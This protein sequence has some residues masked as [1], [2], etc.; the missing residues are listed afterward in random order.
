MFGRPFASV[1]IATSRVIAVA[2]ICAEHGEVDQMVL[3]EPARPE[4]I[5]QH[6]AMADF[7]PLIEFDAMALAI[8]EADRLDVIET[9]QREGEAGGRNPA[10]RKKAP[11]PWSSQY[12]V[13]DIR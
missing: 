11:A 10:R 2:E 9:R 3:A 12:L 6:D 5:A 7:L 8:I 1:T 13:W 4:R